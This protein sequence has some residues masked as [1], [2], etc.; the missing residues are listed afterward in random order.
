[1]S[2]SYDECYRAACRHVAECR[3]SVLESVRDDLATFGDVDELRQR[4]M[5]ECD[6]AATVIYTGQAWAYCLGSQNDDA[7]SAEMGEE[8]KSVEVRACWALMA[9][10]EEDSDWQDMVD[11][12]EN[13][14]VADY[15]ESLKAAA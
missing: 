14:T 10:V 12:V 2:D 6:G 13:D 3:E 11:A 8:P 15:L 9:D 5:E 4:M 1:M 7:Y